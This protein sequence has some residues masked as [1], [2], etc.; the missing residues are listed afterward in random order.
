MSVLNHHL[1]GIQ[2]SSMANSTKSQYSDQLIEEF[3]NGLMRLI[4]KRCK[5]YG[6]K[7]YKRRHGL[8]SDLTWKAKYYQCEFSLTFVYDGVYCWGFIKGK[9]VIDYRIRY[10]NPDCNEDS[11]LKNAILK[12]YNKTGTWNVKEN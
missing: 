6:I 1:Q 8:V 5:P 3:V 2:S 7:F 10:N 4:N 12:W 9:L 11:I